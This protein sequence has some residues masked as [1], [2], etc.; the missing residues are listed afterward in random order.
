[1]ISARKLI[2]GLGNLM[3]KEAYLHA[4]YREGNIPDMY[5]QDISLWEKYADEI[6]ARFSTGIG[7]LEFVSIHVRR[8]D[9]LA[10]NFHT[11]MTSTDYYERAI[12][13]FPKMKF[14]VFSDDTEWC[15]S[16][17]TDTEKFQIMEGGTEEEDLNMMASCAHNIIANSTFSFWAS[18]L[19]PNPVKRIIAPREIMW[20]KDGII[21]LKLPKNYEQI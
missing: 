14:L 8:G 12:E 2:G 6:K 9:Y 15:K 21:R 1:M 4:Q 5:V 13:L 7:F 3:F 18:Y 11:D 10:S 17:F 20:F 16:K 19:N